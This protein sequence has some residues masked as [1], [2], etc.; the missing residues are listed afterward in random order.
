MRLLLAAIAAGAWITGAQ[1]APVALVNPGFESNKPGEGG[2]PE[3]WVAIQHA[4][5]E[6]YDFPLDSSQRKTGVRSLR[7]KRIGP[8]PYGTITQVLPGAPYAGKTVR[9]SA[10]IRTEAVPV[11]RRGGAGLVLSALR[12]SS[13]LAHDHMKNARVQGTTD[14]KRYSIELA[15]PPRTDR[16]ELGAT[17]EG[18][19]TMWIDDV[20]F[21][22]V[23]R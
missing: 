16:L 11:S 7:I 5:E 14:W 12:G 4:G 8:E 17:L 6:S 9:L 15:V 21:E 23:D 19:G 2:N 20:E 13:F 10:W 1:A 22:V 3:G 18:D